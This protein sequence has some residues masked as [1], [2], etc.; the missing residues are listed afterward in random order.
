VTVQRTH[1]KP[2]TTAKT[3]RG[4]HADPPAK[5]PA[6][7]PAV[8]AAAP[9]ASPSIAPSSTPSITPAPAGS[10]AAAQRGE[11]CTAGCKMLAGCRLGSSS[12]EAD[13]AQNRT[14]HNC[15][16][17]AANDCTRFASCWFGTSCKVTPRGT[18]S[19]SE[20]M[21]CEARCRNDQSCI[22]SCVGGLSPAHS[23]ALLAYNGCALGCRDNDC[24]QQRCAAQAR[25][26]RAE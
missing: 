17:L 23:V 12:C 14:L 20:A 19:C 6:S 8:I 7:V 25:R 2:P 24:I 5:T 1:T 21:D 4:R 26:C 22:C 16:Q 3:P 18:H 9:P 15:L 13:C 10:P 11:L